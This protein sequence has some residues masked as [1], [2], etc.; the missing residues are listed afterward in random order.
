[1]L[2]KIKIVLMTSLQLNDVLVIT[3]TIVHGEESL[4]SDFPDL[5]KS[6]RYSFSN[7]YLFLYD[8]GLFHKI[9]TYNVTY[10]VPKIVHW[11]GAYF[12]TEGCNN[13]FPW[14]N[15]R[16]CWWGQSL[17]FFDRYNNMCFLFPPFNDCLVTKK[18]TRY[19]RLFSILNYKM[20]HLTHK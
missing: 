2:K 19:V 18:V 8:L 12:I 1:M 3:K 6:Q 15:Y 9:M 11:K 13:I 14:W 20:S 4:K 7:A 16:Y 17:N 5:M 10:A